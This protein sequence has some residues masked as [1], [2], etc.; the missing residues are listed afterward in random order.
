VKDLG[1]VP[2]AEGF[3]GTSVSPDNRYVLGFKEID[4]G[5]SIAAAPLYLASV[6][7]NWIAPVDGA[8]GLWPK[9]SPASYLVLLRDPASGLVRLGSINVQAH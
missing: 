6:T 8:S 5:E 2:G 9:F 3:V 1:T 7:D 4:E